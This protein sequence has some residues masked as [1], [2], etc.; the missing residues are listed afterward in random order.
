[1]LACHITLDFV[2]FTP[3][4]FGNS[5]CMSSALLCSSNDFF[6]WTKINE[7]EVIKNAEDAVKRLRRLRDF[8]Y[9]GIEVFIRRNEETSIDTERRSDSDVFFAEYDAIWH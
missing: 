1:M 6:S 9:Q 3:V 2:I 4:N 5:K 7:N 8:A